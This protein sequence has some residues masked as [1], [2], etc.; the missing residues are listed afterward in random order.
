M[1]TILAIALGG[2]LGSVMRHYSIAAL[3]NENFPYGTLFVNIVG[4]FLI[5][6]LMEM[7]A[8]KWQVPL[9]TRAFLITGVLGG[10]TTFSAFSLDV[11]KLAETGH[12]VTAIAYVTSSVALSLCAVFGGAYIVRHVVA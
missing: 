9:E 2:A 11:F 7:M 6:F 5:G 4:S 12:A 8:L 3:P 1:N 10:F